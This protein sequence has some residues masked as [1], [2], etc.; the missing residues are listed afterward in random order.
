MIVMSLTLKKQKNISY[1]MSSSSEKK[2]NLEDDL[3]VTNNKN[4]INS[5]LYFLNNPKILSNIILSKIS[6]RKKMMRKR[7][8]VLLVGM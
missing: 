2:K 3:K 4:F 8:K 7:K 1:K 5:L 6:I